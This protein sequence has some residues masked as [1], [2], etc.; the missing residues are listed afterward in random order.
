MAQ[1]ANYPHYAQSSPMQSHIPMWHTIKGMEIISSPHFQN[2]SHPNVPHHT[3]QTETNRTLHKNGNPI[4]GTRCK[5][6]AQRTVSS[7]AQSHPN[8]AH[9]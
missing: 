2:I 1:G 4:N 8:V 6:F 7:N 9:H 5:L 3:V